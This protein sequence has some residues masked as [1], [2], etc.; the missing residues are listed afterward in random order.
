[1]GRAAC[2]SKVEK[3]WFCGTGSLFI[4]LGILFIG[5]LYSWIISER[6]VVH[7]LEE[8]GSGTTMTNLNSTILNELPIQILSLQEQ[9][10]IVQEIESN[11]SVC[12]KLVETI[13]TSLQQAESLR[14]SILKKAFEGSLLTDAELTACREEPDWEPAKKL[15]E[16]LRR[17]ENTGNDRETK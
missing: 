13:D 7:Y 6:R 9:I 15:L 4:R 10:Q 8:K 3:G 17:K 11:L 5:H 16:K 1:M 12:Y 14:Q 2:V